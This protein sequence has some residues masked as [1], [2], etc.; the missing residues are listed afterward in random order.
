M[1]D[2]IR[3]DLNGK[4]NNGK[5]YQETEKLDAQKEFHDENAK[6]RVVKRRWC[7]KRDDDVIKG[8]L[9][10]LL[11]IRSSTNVHTD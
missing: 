10:L 3:I 11:T 9:I 7:C 5:K 1:T 8:I 2:R 6:Y 4:Q